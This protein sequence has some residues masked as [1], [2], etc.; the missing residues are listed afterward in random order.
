VQVPVDVGKKSVMQ[1]K[2][3]NEVHDIAFSMQA[4]Q[5]KASLI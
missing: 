2:F 1:V 3:V 4:T 5:E